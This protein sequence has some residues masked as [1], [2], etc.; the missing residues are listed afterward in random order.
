VR[1]LTQGQCSGE[2]GTSSGGFGWLDVEETWQRRSPVYTRRGLDVDWA[3]GLVKGETEAGSRCTALRQSS[4][5]PSRRQ[6][7][8]DD[9]RTSGQRRRRGCEL[10]EGKGQGESE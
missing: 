4:P 3:E 9:G 8:D 7:P 10:G 5:W 2:L 1:F 6:R